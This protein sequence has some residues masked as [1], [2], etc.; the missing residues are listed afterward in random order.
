M[1]KIRV[2]AVRNVKEILRDPLSYIFALGFPVVMLIIMTIVNNSTLLY[3]PCIWR[4]RRIAG[5]ENSSVTPATARS[6]YSHP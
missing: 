1:S 6:L 3:P 5:K 4:F 2:F